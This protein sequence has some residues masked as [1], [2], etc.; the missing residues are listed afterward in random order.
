MLLVRR[1]SIPDDQFAVLRGR[2]EVALVRAPI[3]AEDLGAVAFEATPDL[4]V[5][6]LDRFDVFRHLRCI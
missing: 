5:E 2:D 1:E 6:A 3:D 4:D